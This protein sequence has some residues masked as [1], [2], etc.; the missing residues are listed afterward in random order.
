MAS[1]C[2]QPVIICDYI[3]SF[4]SDWL[5]QLS[6]WCLCLWS[7]SLWFTL[8]T[9]TR[10]I[11]GSLFGPGSL[12]INGLSGPYWHW[13]KNRDIWN[14]SQYDHNQLLLLINAFCSYS[15]PFLVPKVNPMF[16]HLCSFY[17]LHLEYSIPT[18][19]YHNFFRSYVKC[20][21]CHKSFADPSIQMLTIFVLGCHWLLRHWAEWQALCKFCS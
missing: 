4:L 6:K 10:I 16:S 8:Q 20:Y 3:H 5:Q 9:T 19:H 2:L 18:S 11:F 14:L 13:I 1:I 7:S 21:L 12:Y 15:E 17:P